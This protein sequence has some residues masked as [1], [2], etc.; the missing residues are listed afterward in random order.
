MPFPQLILLKIFNY[1]NILQ[2]I[3]LK[4]VSLKFNQTIQQIIPPKLL[5]SHWISELIKTYHQWRCYPIISSYLDSITI[6]TYLDIALANHKTPPNWAERL[7]LDSCK[8]GSLSSLNWIILRYFR[9]NFTSNRAN[10]CLV[11]TAH[12]HNLL[13]INYLIKYIES[14]DEIEYI[15]RYKGISYRFLLRDLYLDFWRTY[16]ECIRLKNLKVFKYIWNKYPITDHQRIENLLIQCEIYNSH[17]IY[18]L[19]IKESLS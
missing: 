13:M 6:H 15:R 1:I 5:K 12:H 14:D 8:T 9:D 16:I 3:N 10:R 17:K 11:Y 2:I 19:I 7:L 4:L 18:L